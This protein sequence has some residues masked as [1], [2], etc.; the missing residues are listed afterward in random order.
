M[1][2][3]I[4]SA[5]P[6]TGLERSMLRQLTT[7]QSAEAD[8][9]QFIDGLILPSPYTLSGFM[10][11]SLSAPPA[12]F[13]I[14]DS[15]LMGG[16]L[17]GIGICPQTGLGLIIKPPVAPDAISFV[18]VQLSANASASVIL[19]DNDGKYSDEAPIM[20]NGA[21]QAGGLT[22]PNLGGRYPTFGVIVDSDNSWLLA[23]VVTNRILP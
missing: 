23:R 5:N 15:A 16:P 9:T 4:A 22:I 17:L 13:Q 18:G 3:T 8:F 20:M 21:L 10:L 14:K 12:A 1:G 11:L 6:K 19:Y 2:S 7:F